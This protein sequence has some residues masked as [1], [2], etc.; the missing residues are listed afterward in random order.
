MTSKTVEKRKFHYIDT[1][2]AQ[3]T[4]LNSQYIEYDTQPITE[5]KYQIST[6]QICGNSAYK[7]FEHK[8]SISQLLSEPLNEWII[9]RAQTYTNSKIIQGIEQFK[10]NT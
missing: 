10:K 8:Y 9:R 6:L 1:S 2:W 4:I 7:L 5:N 3:T